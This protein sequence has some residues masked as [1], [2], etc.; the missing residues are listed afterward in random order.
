M[1]FTKR[2]FVEQAM[3]EIGMATNI[4]DL[5]ADDLLRGCQRLDTMM[6][7]WNGQ[8][9]RLGY[10]Q[11]N[12]N[13]VD[14]DTDTGIPD[15]ANEAVIANLAIVLAPAFGRTPMPETR[16]AATRGM[17]AMR[18]QTAIPPLMQFPQ[19]LPVGSGN[20]PW[21]NTNNPFFQPV[22]EIEVGPDGTLDLE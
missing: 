3:A 10:P 17:N 7:S 4:F 11:S 12:P 18:T 5:Q 13:D 16:V 8:G 22:D 9:I 2:Q 1:S 14:P 6:A 15:W 19:T 21:R 20:K